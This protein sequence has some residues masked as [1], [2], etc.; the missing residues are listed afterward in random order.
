MPIEFEAKVLDVVPDEVAHRVLR[1]GGRR[2][3]ARLMRG[4]CMT[5]GRGTSRDGFGCGMTVRR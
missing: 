3:G 5:F 2:M 4:M 1:L